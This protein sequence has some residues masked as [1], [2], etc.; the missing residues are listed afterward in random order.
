[1][2]VTWRPRRLMA[3]DVTST[4]KIV[5]GAGFGLIGNIILGIIGAIV[6]GWL[7]PRVGVFIGGDIIGAIINALIGAVI[8]LV[9]VI[10]VRRAT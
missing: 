2:Q 6:A 9:I 4:E 1:M 7:L 3:V 8:V 10:L 5:E